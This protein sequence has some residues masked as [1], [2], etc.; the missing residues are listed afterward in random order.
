MSGSVGKD[1][2]EQERERAL[3]EFSEYQPLKRKT[4]FDVVMVKC[5]QYS[6]FT[7]AVFKGLFQCCSLHWRISSQHSL[8]RT[9]LA[10]GNYLIHGL[11]HTA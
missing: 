3:K 9:L 4:T 7:F 1:V 2:G 6:L 11:A 10:T 8:A 5:A